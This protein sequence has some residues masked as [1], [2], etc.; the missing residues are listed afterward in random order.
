MQEELSAEEAVDLKEQQVQAQQVSSLVHLQTLGSCLAWSLLSSAGRDTVIQQSQPHPP[1]NTS[2]ADIVISLIFVCDRLVLMCQVSS[3]YLE[4]ALLLE[5]WENKGEV[6]LRDCAQGLIK[7][8]VKKKIR[9]SVVCISAHARLH[10]LEP[11]WLNTLS[12]IL[13]SP[14][15][16]IYCSHFT[17]KDN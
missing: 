5:K 15:D 9:C 7:T 8:L 17:P 16:P 11:N 10:S 1:S 4:L 3:K 2:W 6:W 12:V 13:S 14:S